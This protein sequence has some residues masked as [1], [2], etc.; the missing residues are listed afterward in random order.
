MCLLSIEQQT[1]KLDQLVVVLNSILLPDEFIS[2]IYKCALKV[3][4]VKSEG[5]LRFGPALNLGLE[6]IKGEYIFRFDPDDIYFPH[7]V[8]SQYKYLLSNPEID[9]LGSAIIEFSDDNSPAHLHQYPVGWPAI[10]KELVK[11]NPLAHPSVVIRREIFHDLKGYNDLRNFEDYELWIR[12]LKLGFR[13]ENLDY[14]L[15]KYRIDI[16]NSKK[17][18]LSLI[19]I[20]FF[21]YKELYSFG[22]DL[23]T[24]IFRFL[25]R[26]IY[27]ITPKSL[28][29]LF[30][31]IIYLNPI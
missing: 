31:K 28:R 23:R 16:I 5:F 13:I 29:Y 14:P 9:I 18:N 11:N 8:E 20:D 24:I 17:P 6:K 7:R 30:R 21:V 15:V 19:P 26:I 10:R 4:I 12:A 2:L 25:L 27:R 22:F 1:Q 3:D